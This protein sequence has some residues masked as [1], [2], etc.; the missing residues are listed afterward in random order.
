MSEM[1]NVQ[2]SERPSIK[3]L[4]GIRNY[5]LLWL[6]QVISDFGNNMTHLALLLLVNELTNSAAAIATMTIMISLPRLVFGLLSGIFVD[7]LNR[8]HIM[9]ISDLSRGLLV[10]GFILVDSV[11]RIWILYLIGLLQGC[12]ATFFDPA[13]SAL[14]PNLI[15]KE[16]LLSANSV[17]QTSQIIFGLL[18]T[19]A[20]GFLVG[21]FHNYGIIFGIDALTF[22]ISMLLISAIRYQFNPDPK[23]EKL[24]PALMFHQLKD[25][26]QV[27]FG[28]PYLSGA[29]LSI[30]ITMLGIGAVNVLLVPL[31]VNVL[32]VPETWFAGIEFAQTAAMVLSGGVIVS[33]AARLKPT[34]LLGLGLFGLGMGIALLSL[35]GN[36]YG[37]ILVLFFTALFVPAINTSTQTI[38]QTCV[39]DE[40]RG[41]ASAARSMLVDTANLLSM[42]AAGVL[43][44]SIGVRTF[45][46]I[47][48]FFVLLAALVS[49]L[50]FKRAEKREPILQNG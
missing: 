22:F 45:F 33:L 40:I 23:R 12:V 17:S 46:M 30:S 26:L 35:V 19:G 20:A 31:L 3:M 41:R 18:G 15:A 44:D 9:V 24:S 38:I 27:T 8:K 11:D 7:R 49:S 34:R 13:R 36:V 14:L 42:G 1:E 6:G 37:V 10:L 43:V 4:F 47:G 5:R 48:G 2:V 16:Y 50:V 21:V 39:A 29:I 32:N 25:G 28:N